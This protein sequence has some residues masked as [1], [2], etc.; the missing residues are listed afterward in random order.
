[1]IIQA[2]KESAMSNYDGQKLI[3]TLAVAAFVFAIVII[4]VRMLG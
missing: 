4:S 3:P 1:L 2:R